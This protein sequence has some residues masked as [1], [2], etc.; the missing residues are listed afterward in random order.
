MMLKDAPGGP[1]FV[2]SLIEAIK[3]FALLYAGT[4]DE[5][6][7]P[8][9]ESYLASIE[10]GIVDA[11]GASNAPIL[12]DGFRRAVFTRKREI[13]AAGASRA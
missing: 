6:A 13:E 5:Q 2:D 9:L 8:H 11:V 10:T 3:S 1:Q 7:R 4:A 12:L